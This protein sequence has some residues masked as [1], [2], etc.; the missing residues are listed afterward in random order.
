MRSQY[1]NQSGSQY[2]NNGLNLHAPSYDQDGPTLKTL[3]RTPSMDP[4]QQQYGSPNRDF[5]NHQQGL[6]H[7]S[8]RQYQQQGNYDELRNYQSNRQQNLPQYQ[9][10]QGEDGGYGNDQY[11]IRGGIH[12]HHQVG[13]IVNV[14]KGDYIYPPSE[15]LNQYPSE[16]FSDPNS[17]NQ[18]FSHDEYHQQHQFHRG[19]AIRNQMNSNNGRQNYSSNTQNLTNNGL[20]GLRTDS[21]DYQHYSPSKDGAMGNSGLLGVSKTRSLDQ[22]NGSGLVQGHLRN[23]PNSLG[24]HPVGHSGLRRVINSGPNMP[25][26]SGLLQMNQQIP[27]NQNYY[28]GQQEQFGTSQ[29]DVGEDDGFGMSSLQSGLQYYDN[30]RRGAR[31]SDVVDYETTYSEVEDEIPDHTSLHS[32]A[33]NF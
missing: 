23:N 9:D 25:D 4:H 13:K 20:V 1:L 10:D 30:R 2:G 15:H 11:N 32:G 3:V 12:R 26:G 24:D 29:E 33:S 22:D 7:Q 21:Q 18:S 14:N 17:A 27:L 5:A 8:M 16:S 6:S 28:P 19:A 31:E